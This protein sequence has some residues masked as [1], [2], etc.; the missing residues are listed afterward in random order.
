M[1]APMQDDERRKL[2][3]AAIKRF[4]LAAAGA[5]GAK[6]AERAV[7]WVLGNGDDESDYCKTT[8]DDDR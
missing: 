5:A 2:A 8:E 1:L 6:L 4:V 3:W 7:D